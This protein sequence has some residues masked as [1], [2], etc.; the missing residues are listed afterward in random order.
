MAFQ[1]R[2]GQFRNNLSAFFFSIVVKFLA[3]PA[4][5][6]CA[7]RRALLDWRRRQRQHVEHVAIARDAAAIGTYE[8]RDWRRAR[9]DR[10]T[11]RR[12][13]CNDA[14]KTDIQ[15]DPFTRYESNFA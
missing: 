4:V 3:D 10:E 9:A 5:S 7:S 2:K 8:C 1:S 13:V 15:R 11:T 12:T 14:T 6:I